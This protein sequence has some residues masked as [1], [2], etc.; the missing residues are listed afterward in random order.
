[1]SRLHGIITLFL[2]AWL[3]SANEI[4]AQTSEPEPGVFSVETNYDVALRHLFHFHVEATGLITFFP[5]AMEEPAP[6]VTDGETPLA[7]AETEDAAGTVTAATSIMQTGD[8]SALF[9]SES[10]EGSFASMA[11]GSWMAISLD[12]LAF[13]FAMAEIIDDTTTIP[14]PADEAD[15]PGA[16]VDGEPDIAGDDAQAPGGDYTMLYG[17]AFGDALFGWVRRHHD[18]ALPWG[19]LLLTGLIAADSADQPGGENLTEEPDAEL[20]PPEGEGDVIP[21]MP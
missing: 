15:P 12:G 6:P 14:Q 11:L 7:T 19:R 16:V 13:W 4:S 21:T 10:D 2:L 20:V 17:F 8:F 18:P 9:L 1:M 5:P 3:L